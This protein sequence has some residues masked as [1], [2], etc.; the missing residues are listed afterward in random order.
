MA[1]LCFGCKTNEQPQT[2]IY[3][4][5]NAQQQQI[6]TGFFFYI[7]IPNIN[8]EQSGKSVDEPGGP[9]PPLNITLILRNYLQSESYNF[10]LR[11]VN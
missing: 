11:N 7:K 3:K 1:N 4:H 10:L 6:M 5:H 8:K 9:S 2:A